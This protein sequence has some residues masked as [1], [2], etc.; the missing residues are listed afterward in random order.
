LSAG[1][2]VV[3]GENQSLHQHLSLPSHLWKYHITLVFAF[4]EAV[5]GVVGQIAELYPSAHLIGLNV[6]RRVAYSAFQHDLQQL[7]EETTN[8]LNNL[9]LVI[10]RQS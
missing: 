9:S 4:D 5:E 6:Q 8:T 2:V 10:S 7:S 1:G 3:F